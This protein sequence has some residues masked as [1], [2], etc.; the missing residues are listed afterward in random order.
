MTSQAHSAAPDPDGRPAHACNPGLVHKSAS[1][2]TSS[3][4]SAGAAAR[5]CAADPDL[6]EEIEQVLDAAA[7]IDEDVSGDG[8]LGRPGHVL[9]VGCGL[10]IELAHLARNGWR[11]CGTDLSSVALRRSQAAHPGIPFL[12]ASAVGDRW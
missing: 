10:G 6:G 4:R 3:R 7:V 11:G 12:R 8:W 5:A 9:D 1:T 2:E